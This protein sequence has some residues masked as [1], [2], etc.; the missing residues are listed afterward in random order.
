MNKT[1]ILYNFIENNKHLPE[2]GSQEWLKSRGETIGGSEI[3]TVLGI[4]PYQNIKKLIFQKTGLTKF[5]KS[6]PLW[7]GN[8]MEYILQQY[9]EM[10]FNTKI[11]ET[12]AIKYSKSNYLKYSPDG[13]AVINIDYIKHLFSQE[14]IENFIHNKSK[15]DNKLEQNKNEL[16]ILFEFKN[17]YMRRLKQGIVPEYY[18]PQP[19]MGLNVIDICEVSIFIEAIYRF[20][21]YEDIVNQNNKYN[22]RY[23]FDKQRYYNDPIAYGAFSLYYD[24]KTNKSKHFIKTIEMLIEYLQDNKLPNNDLSSIKNYKII[25]MIMENIIDYKD[26]KIKYHNNLFINKK[27]DKNNLFKKYNNINMFKNE[28]KNNKFNVDNSL[29]YLGNFCFKLFDIN[30]NPIFKKENMFDEEL[31]TKIEKIIKIIKECN[32]FS[33]QDDK[34]KIIK[35]FFKLENNII[36][37]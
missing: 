21:S 6:A 32:N 2:Q 13:I 26:I 12:G 18:I 8:I 33:D 31:L 23:H 29:V 11:Y 1:E 28:I 4:N 7:F 20:C 25:N 24:N 35:E 37:K 9:T 17:P 16:I 15:F 5:N 22:T 19:E 27:E 36:L 14:E 30:I 34:K 3:S 10:V